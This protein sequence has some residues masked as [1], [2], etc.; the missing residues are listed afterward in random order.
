MSEHASDNGRQDS[1]DAWRPNQA[2]AESI[3][4]YEDDDT[5]VFFDADNPLA[6][7]ETTE[8]VRLNERT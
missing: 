6:W 4:A 7:V 8:A 2:R 1:A 3:E 5:V